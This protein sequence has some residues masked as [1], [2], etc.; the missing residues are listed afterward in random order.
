MDVLMLSRRHCACIWLVAFASN[1]SARWILIANSWM[2]HPVGYVLKNGR[3]SGRLRTRKADRLEPRLAT[4]PRAEG[5]AASVSGE[6]ILRPMN[7]SLY[8]QAYYVKLFIPIFLYNDLCPEEK[9]NISGAQGTEEI[10]F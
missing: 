9:T 10:S 3:A 6:Q 7:F 1:L 5:M 2:Q 8:K 4:G